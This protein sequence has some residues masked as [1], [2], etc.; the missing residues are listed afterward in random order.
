MTEK[1]KRVRPQL[2]ERVRPQLRW[3]DCVKKEVRK[4]EEE[5]KRREKA[6]DREQGKD[7]SWGSEA[8]QEGSCLN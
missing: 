1:R 2:I 3:E 6:A 5:D 4:A 7:N 8:T